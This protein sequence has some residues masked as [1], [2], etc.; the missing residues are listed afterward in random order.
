MVPNPSYSG[1]HAAVVSNFVGVPFTSDA[2]QFNAI[3]AGSID[4]DVV[5]PEDAPELSSLKALGY[6]YFGLPDFG[7]YFATYNFQDKTGDFNNIVSQLYF[8]QAMQHL[9]DQHGPDQ[10]LP[11]RGGQ[12]D[13]H[14]HLAVPEEPV[15]AGQ[16]G[17]QSLPVQ[18]RAG[19]RPC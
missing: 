9:E 12:P 7:N 15:P 2:A 4:V 16:R 17:E 18:R 11:Q 1:P 13:L 6:A 5:P 3:K 14:R 10:G 8:R 19:G